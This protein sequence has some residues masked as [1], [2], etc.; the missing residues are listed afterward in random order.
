MFRRTLFGPRGTRHLYRFAVRDALLELSVN[1]RCSAFLLVVRQFTALIF[2]VEERVFIVSSMS[3]VR[4]M[5]IGGAFAVGISDL[6]RLQVEDLFGTSMMA[7]GDV[8]SSRSLLLGPEHTAKR[9]SL[10]LSKLLVETDRLQ[11]L[12]LTMFK[13]CS[14]NEIFIASMSFIT[15]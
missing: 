2:F 10:E 8:I 1:V 12:T 6:L 9:L 13:N 4:I 7:H 3:D 14:P 5:I 11:F 15:Y